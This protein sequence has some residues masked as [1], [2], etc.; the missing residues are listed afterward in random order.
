MEVVRLA[1]AK[2]D[3]GTYGPGSDISKGHPDECITIANGTHY[4]IF[5][6][7]PVFRGM[8]LLLTVDSYQRQ[9]EPLNSE[10]L[11]VAWETMYEMEDEHFVFYNCGFTAGASRAHKHVQVVPAPGA[12]EGY[13]EEFKFWPDYAS[14][15]GD[16]PPPLVHFIQRYE[17]LPGGSIKDTAQLLEIYLGMLQKAREVLQLSDDVPC[18][19]NFIMTKKWMLVIPRRAK[20]YN[21]ISANSP[22]MLGSVYIS[23]HEQVDRWK[24]FGPVTTLTHLGLLDEN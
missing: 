10:D 13:P 12:R 24:E 7:F 21:E 11:S 18:P 5:N 16:C 4:I 23:N 2:S 19:H 9:D 6:K 3:P 14:G 22:G 1:G 8:L 20:L 17:Q 15:S